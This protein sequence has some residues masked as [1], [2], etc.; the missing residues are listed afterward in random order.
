MNQIA[1]RFLSQVDETDS[2]LP[3]ITVGVHKCTLPTFWFDV[4]G[5]NQYLQVLKFGI[6]ALFNFDIYKTLHGYHLVSVRPDYDDVQFLLDCTK[7]IFSN[8]D[9][10]RSCRKL[11]L[12]IGPKWT[13]DGKEVS[14]APYLLLCRCANGVHVEHRTGE[15]VIYRTNE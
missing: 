5:E 6:Q 9:Y 8:S 3:I 11:R 4:D 15:L 14:P 2:K 7:E 12:R 13:K 10:I 1:V